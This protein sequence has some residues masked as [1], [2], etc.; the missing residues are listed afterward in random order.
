MITDNDL[1]YKSVSG[2]AGYAIAWFIEEECVFAQAINKKYF[3]LFTSFNNAL[4]ISD[5]YPNHNGITVRLMKNN[6]ILEDIQT[7]EFFGSILLSNPIVV[8]LMELPYGGYVEPYNCKLINNEFVF[9]NMDKS[10]LEPY[11]GGHIKG[12]QKL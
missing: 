2:Y 5:Q 4:D 7:S 8:D 10:N 6:E 1:I 12:G 11:P 9:L 3:D